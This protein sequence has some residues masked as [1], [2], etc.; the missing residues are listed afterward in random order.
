[1]AEASYR[2]KKPGRLRRI[3][4]GS[5]LSFASVLLVSG[6]LTCTASSPAKTVAGE[7]IQCPAAT[8]V[9]SG[10][11]DTIRIFSANVQALPHG[12]DDM[13]RED[14]P[15]PVNRFECIGN[16]I[17]QHDVALL[18][19]DFTQKGALRRAALPFTWNP[20]RGQGPLETNSGITI[21]ARQPFEKARS[22]AYE[23]CH[24]GLGDAV[25]YKLAKVFGARFSSLNTQGDC[26]ANKSFKVAQ[27]DGVTLITSH[28]D[29]GSTAGDADARRAQFEQLDRATPKTGPLVVGMDANVKENIA[30]DEESLLRYMRSN[31]LTLA[32]RDETDVILTRG[33][34]VVEAHRIP[35]EDLSDHA[36]LSVTVRKAASKPGL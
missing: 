4:K 20:E 19:E 24:G 21:L 28:L 16:I 11:P 3:F 32:F 2:A 6:S 15:Y 12:L 27:M 13:Q 34:E 26:L 1:M 33:V 22:E 35:L 30:K 17:E 23:T 10:A 9:S 36:G 29:A 7:V 8:P 25:P 5:K 14:G 18:Q 31:G